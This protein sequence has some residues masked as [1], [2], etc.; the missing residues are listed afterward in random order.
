MGGDNRPNRCFIPDPVVA[1]AVMLVF[2]GVRPW[3]YRFC[4]VDSGSTFERGS[5]AVN[6]SAAFTRA[7][8]SLK[9]ILT[10]KSGSVAADPLLPFT[11]RL[12]NGVT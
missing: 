1:T 2:D 10:T 11:E 9:R 8:S 6:A 4:V 5:A 12:P 7:S 3:I